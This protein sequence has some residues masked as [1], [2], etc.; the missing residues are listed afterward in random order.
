M[1]TPGSVPIQKYPESLIHN[2]DPLKLIPRELDI[3]PTAF[4]NTTMITYEIE[5]R[6]D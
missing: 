4:S 3:T 1:Q 5:V 6:S 2:S